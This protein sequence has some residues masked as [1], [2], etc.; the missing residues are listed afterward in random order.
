MAI[1]ETAV[2]Q[3]FG[4]ISRLKNTRRMFIGP[5][6]IDEL[7]TTATWV[8]Q[9]TANVPEFFTTDAVWDGLE[10]EPTEPRALGPILMRAARKGLCEPTDQYRNSRRVQC[11]AR[12]MR[13]WR[14]L[15]YGQAT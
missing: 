4:G 6:M 8:L 5:G 12:P 15:T 9:Q 11:H 13:V 14:S 1:L 2:A 7:A 10:V 3:N